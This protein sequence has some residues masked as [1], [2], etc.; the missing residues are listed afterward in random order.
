GIDFLVDGLERLVEHGV[1][2]QVVAPEETLLLKHLLGRGVRIDALEMLAD[3]ATLADQVT[4]AF[5]KRD[6]SEAVR[7][8]Q[9]MLFTFPGIAPGVVQFGTDEVRAAVEDADAAL[10]RIL[11]AIPERFTSESDLLLLLCAGVASNLPE[12]EVLKS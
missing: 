3:S 2:V 1:Q 8:G 11:A 5:Q 12:K 7:Q 10:G 4:A 9:L 6:A